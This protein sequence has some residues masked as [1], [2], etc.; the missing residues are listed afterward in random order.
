MRRDV[1]ARLELALSGQTTAYLSIA[2]ALP[3]PLVAESE[4]L[5]V[6]L[7]GEPVED[8]TETLDEHGSRFHT[9]RAGAGLLQ[10]SYDASVAGRADQAPSSD[11]DLLTFVRP[12]RYCESDAL[13][14][15]AR[16]EFGGLT[17]HDLLSAVS[18][19]VHSRI[20]YTIGSSDPTDGAVQ[21]MLA[22]QGI[23]RDF[24]HLCVAMLRANDVP[25][26]TV[27]VYAPGLSPMDFHAVCEAWVDGEWCVVDATWLAPRQSLLRISTGRDA[28]DTAFVTTMGPAAMLTHLE[29]GAVVDELPGDDWRRVAY[30][31]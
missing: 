19:W 12:S 8:V 5:L 15:T 3:A 14:P 29:V 18:E 16:S 6:T 2:A 31:R 22:R 30:L 21:T 10:V 28:A 20:S 7:D 17:G 13:G 11:L 27:A 24:A 4:S 26:R 25:A 1:T 9:V 23:C